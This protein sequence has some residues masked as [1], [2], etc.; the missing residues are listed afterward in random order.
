MARATIRVGVD[1]GGTFTDIVSLNVDGEVAVGKVR[2]APGGAPRE[3]WDSLDR[4]H[5][6]DTDRDAGGLLVHGTT[7]A[8]NALLERTGEDAALHGMDAFRIMVSNGAFM[9]R[10]GRT[11][12]A[13]DWRAQTG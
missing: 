13:T 7:V 3:L 2:S 10:R 5:E 1:V 6:G 8:T 11:V 12:V 9:P 4:I